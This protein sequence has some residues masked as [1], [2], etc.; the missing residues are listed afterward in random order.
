MYEAMYIPTN[1]IYKPTMPYDVLA[2]YS[3]SYYAW[4]SI[5][6][7]RMRQHIYSRAYWAWKKYGLTILMFGIIWSFTWVAMCQAL[8]MRCFIASSCRPYKDLKPAVK[9]LKTAVNTF[10]TYQWEITLPIA[11]WIFPPVHEFIEA[12]KGNIMV[13]DA[14]I[15]QYET[16]GMIRPEELEPTP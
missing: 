3:E 9:A 13:Y 1:V 7:R 14:L 8:G 12:C 11:P 10:D 2:A 15:Y 5:T 6:N 16:S 4:E